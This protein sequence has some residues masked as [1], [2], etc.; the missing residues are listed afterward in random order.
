MKLISDQ[1]F[2]TTELEHC[3][4]K[5]TSRA[6]PY[7]IGQQYGYSR[8]WWQFYKSNI[9]DKKNLLIIDSSDELASIWP[10][11]LRTQYL[12][13]GIHIIG[14][15]D[16][17]MTDYCVP[18]LTEPDRFAAQLFKAITF[19]NSKRI[20]WDYL[21]INIPN[22]TNYLR[23][24]TDL[25][26]NNDLKNLIW[27]TKKYDN[28]TY[29]P[30]ENN[31]EH[32]V[33]NL[34]SKTRAD[35]RKYLKIFKSGD[36]RF[37][38]IE[39]EEILKYLPELIK[40]NSHTWSIFK[41]KGKV[42]IDFITNLIT[43]ESVF[44]NGKIILPVLFYEDKVIACVFGYLNNGRCFLHTAGILRTK[45]N[46][47]S[48]G[49]TLYGLLIKHFFETGIDVIDLSPGIEDYKLRL[50]AKIE[51]ITQLIVFK[52][53]F[54]Y[55]IYIVGTILLKFKKNVKVFKSIF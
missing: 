48:P 43:T 30:L 25:H 28:Y 1:E 34:G 20:K 36:F 42:N 31:F 54:S 49:I 24:D 55:F 7:D 14:Q 15:I 35:V 3:W 22:W 19:I 33:S 50:N 18:I 5:I 40:L 16:G 46:S 2:L 38:V 52:N 44:T 6:I 10:F 9:I 8:L 39:G 23:T 53:T 17:I 12:L 37:L 47:L 27:K 13:N 4:N 41:G 45:V 11:M 26:L 51:S 32:Y 29:I 21:K